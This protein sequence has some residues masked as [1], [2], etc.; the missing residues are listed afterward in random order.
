MQ[1]VKSESVLGNSAVFRRGDTPFRIKSAVD[2]F[3]AVDFCGLL[4]NGKCSSRVGCIRWLVGGS[5]GHASSSREGRHFERQ[6]DSGLGCHCVDFLEFLE[7]F[8]RF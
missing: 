2:S 1:W 8:R 4:K 5:L 7:V 3:V 6:V